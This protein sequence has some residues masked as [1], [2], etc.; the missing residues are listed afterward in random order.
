M[1]RI[2]ITGATG[3]IG[4]EV[5]HH[6]FKLDNNAEIIAA[7][8]NLDNAKQQF[9]NLSGLNYRV[10][11]FQDQDTFNS[12]FVGIAILFLLRPPQISKVDT[13]FRPLLESAKNNG[14]DKVVFLSV[15]GADKSKVIPHNQIERLIQSM[16]FSYIFARPSYFMQNLTTSLLPE[17]QNNRSITLPS[18]TA[19]FNWIDVKNIGEVLALFL[20]SFENYQNEVY[21]I[22]GTENKNFQEVIEI[23]SKATGLK[24]TYISTNPLSFYL[25]KRKNGLQSGFALVMTILHF[26]PRFEKEPK[27][28]D[29]FNKLTGKKPTL[30]SEFINRER[31]T[32]TTTGTS[33]KTRN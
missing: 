11:D 7:V 20:T 31:D 5:V 14:I 8:R 12:A 6:L 17:L 25:L 22:T 4:M 3:T 1:K 29:S 2:L 9:Y 16:G 23:L 24:F 32:F 15:Q 30:L 33:I 10:F 13:Y 18:G 26:L 19:K 28:S 21:D 27:I